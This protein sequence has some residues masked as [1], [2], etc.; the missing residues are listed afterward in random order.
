MNQKV[1]ISY[2][3]FENKTLCMNTFKPG[4]QIKLKMSEMMMGAVIVVHKRNIFS[5]IV[6]LFKKK[7]KEILERE[8]VI[9]ELAHEKNNIEAETTLA[10]K[11]IPKIQIDP[12]KTSQNSI[13]IWPN[14]VDGFLN[15]DYNLINAGQLKVSVVPLNKINAP[16]ILLFKGFRTKGRHEDTYSADGLKNGIYVLTITQ[17]NNILEKHKIM[18]KHQ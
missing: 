13:G 4:T 2:I 17:N 14:P 1:I 7:H 5:R 10:V 11:N 3:G 6:H 9:C 18:V 16:E 12:K 8:E 15:L